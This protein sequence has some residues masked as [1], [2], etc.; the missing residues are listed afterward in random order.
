MVMMG[1][2]ELAGKGAA[3][4]NSSPQRAYLSEARP[5]CRALAQNTKLGEGPWPPRSFSFLGSQP[6]VCPWL[7]CKQGLEAREGEQ[8]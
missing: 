6:L 4:L 7:N 1:K 5:G 8:V 3:G 2:V